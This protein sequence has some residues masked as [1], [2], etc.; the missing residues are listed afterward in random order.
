MDKVGPS[1]TDW[2][3]LVVTSN[4]K[5]TV[6]VELSD[7]TGVT[8]A[9]NVIGQREGNIVIGDGSTVGGNLVGG[10]TFTQAIFADGSVD[11]IVGD[12]PASWKELDTN[13]VDV[14]FGA[15]CES[16]GDFAFRDCSNLNVI[17]FPPTLKTLG[18]NVFEGTALTNVNVPSS[19][20]TLGTALF[21]DC[22]NLLSATFEEGLTTIPASTF[23]N[24]SNFTTF[25][26]PSTIEEVG[27]SAFS[28]TSLFGFNFDNIRVIGLSAFQ[29]TNLLG[30]ITFPEGVESI[31]FAFKCINDE[32][33]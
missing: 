22:P 1:D 10:S 33:I 18:N 29:G 6:D 8:L 21:K 2:E 31:L 9:E 19:L 25:N 15:V 13:V 30:N 4:G 7:A 27:D 32:M 11:I 14:V 17:D 5:I 16:V 24:C 3:V 23:A 26:K 28:G 20:T 12:V